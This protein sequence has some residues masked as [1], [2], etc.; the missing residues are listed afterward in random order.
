MRNSAALMRICTWNINSVRIRLHLLEAL[1]RTHAPDV[2]ALQEIKA[3][4]HVFPYDAIRAL[5]YPHISICG[6]KGYHGVALLSRHP[7]R[8]VHC[9]KLLDA[10]DARHIAATLPDGTELHNFYVPAGG[11]IPNRE[12]NPYYGFKLDYVVAMREWFS[13]HRS[14]EHRMILV[15]D[16]NVAP[17]EHDV[18][19][20]KQLL[21]IVSHTPAEVERL[22]ALYAAL[23][24]QDAARHFTPHPEKLY[25]WWSYR[26]K[27]WRASNRGRRLDH[28]WVTP[29][30]VPAL[31]R[32]ETLTDM[33]DGTQPSDHVPIVL[34]LKNA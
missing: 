24:W 5:G 13:K 32:V 26:N 9:L 11:D 8:D 27:D 28:I 3:Q 15:G 4:E 19:S 29:P 16:L 30:L 1:A 31:A 18:W 22:E 6:Q 17:G 21:K 10:P 25:S 33:R 7:L 23:N 2:I 34:T 14:A 20:H 12:E